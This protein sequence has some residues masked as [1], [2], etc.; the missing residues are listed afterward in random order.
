MFGNSSES[1]G[2]FFFYIHYF[3]QANMVEHFLYLYLI[4]NQSAGVFENIAK[5][6]KAESE[7]EK[8]HDKR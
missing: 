1:S 4:L 6:P 8:K 3:L 2:F 7:K 5:K